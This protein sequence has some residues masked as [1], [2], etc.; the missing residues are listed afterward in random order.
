MFMQGEGID[1]DRE[2]GFYWIKKAAQQGMSQAEYKLALC[3][4]D[5]IGTNKDYQ[6][7]K[8]LLTKLAKAGNQDAI[9]IPRKS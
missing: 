4:I 8:H 9:E 1:Q 2:Q 7:A 5:G 3:Y 6:K